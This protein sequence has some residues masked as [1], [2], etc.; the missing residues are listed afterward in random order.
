MFNGLQR[1][2]VLQQKLWSQTLP[3]VA[4][5]E[6]DNQYPVD[7]LR[8]ESKTNE[9]K[10]NN[11]NEIPTVELTAGQVGQP[12]QVVSEKE[13]LQQIFEEVTRVAEK[14]EISSS[15]SL[16]LLSSYE[17]RYDVQKLLKYFGREEE[18]Q[19]VT[20]SGGGKS[21]LMSYVRPIPVSLLILT[22]HTRRT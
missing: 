18:E 10:T 3:N 8:N 2:Q 16:E 21:I 7:A 17:F 14:L 19:D 22:Y 5:R 12:C 4:V 6:Q 1:S 15:K 13:T 9:S 11:S 20:Q